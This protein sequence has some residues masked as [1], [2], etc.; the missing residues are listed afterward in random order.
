ME[1][2]TPHSVEM[3]ATA[4]LTGLK[5]IELQGE[6]TIEAVA[7]EAA[8]PPKFSMLAYAGG[9]ISPK[10]TPP[11]PHQIVIDLAGVDLQKQTRPAL[12][13]H[14]FRFL[15][16]HTTAIQQDGRQLTAAGVVSGIGTAAREVMGAAKNGFQ[17]PVSVGASLSNIE[18]IKAGKSANVN[19]RTVT[20][21]VFIARASK[22]REISFLSMAADEDA[23]ASIAATQAAER[24]GPMTPFQTW[25]AAMG[26]SEDGLSE[27]SRTKLQAKYDLEQQATTAT[28]TAT[29]TA[30]RPAG[31]L[32][33]VLNAEKSREERRKKI[34]DLTAK[35]LQDYPGRIDVV[36]A[37]SRQAVEG[38]WEA[39]RFELALLRAG[40]PQGSFRSRN[41]DDDG[42]TGQVIE[43]ALCMAGGMEDEKLQKHF[44]EPVLEAANKRWR[45]GLGL[46][47]S[48]LLFARRNGCNELSARNVGPVLRAAFAEPSVSMQASV[49]STLS[50][51]GIFANT[52]NKFMRAGFE[53]VDSSWRPIAAIRPVKDFK[54]ISTYTLTGGFD[55]TEVPAGG[56]LE[57]AEAGEQSYTNQAKTYGRMFVLDRRDIIN[58]DI[59]ALTTV[60]KRLG[61]GGAL[62]LNK[63]F[64]TIFLNNSAF[65]TTGRTNYLAGATPGT[66]DTRMNIEGL[67]RAE[68]LFFNQTD[69]DGNIMAAAPKILLV[70][71]ALNAS[72]MALMS[73]TEIRDTTSSTT[74]PINN[75]HA[76]K[77][78][79]VRSPYLSDSTIT[80]YSAAAWYLLADPNDVP[81]IEVAFLNG[82]DTPTVESADADFDMLGIQMRG[83]WDFGVALQEYRGGVKMKGAA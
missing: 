61:R 48:L 55:F 83:F 32:D 62:K 81:V 67:G 46:Q 4:V 49:P 21:P 65:F 9:P 15:V 8:G 59:G 18:L 72:A 71:S 25:L 34:I 7:D 60:P 2:T 45:H 43:A 73:S 35:A 12:K 11:L 54:Q 42:L 26:L 28:A 75:P 40:R 24:K 80:G 33:A 79:V 70:P 47:E 64:W 74:F 68:T 5:D 10:L 78:N 53:A 6:A 44:D 22:L 39:D 13:D 82:A 66:D 57:H 17:W 23:V 52:A 56:K 19:G 31:D 36:E 76:G 3:R 50:L 77:W 30:N 41:R 1:T 16:G 63:V 27:E 37:L 29:A 20:G 69:P 58:D 51:P 14:D 38:D